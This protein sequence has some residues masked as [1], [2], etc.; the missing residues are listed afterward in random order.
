M[1]WSSVTTKKEIK[2]VSVQVVSCC[3]YDNHPKMMHNM[4]GSISNMFDCL[5]NLVVYLYLLKNSM[6]IGSNMKQRRRVFPYAT[7]FRI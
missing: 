4:H 6:T 1:A 3:V 7:I 5:T 2:A